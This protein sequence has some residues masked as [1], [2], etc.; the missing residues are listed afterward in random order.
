MHTTDT[1]SSSLGKT[2]QVY[3]F[4]YKHVRGAILLAAAI[5]TVPVHAN[6]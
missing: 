3:T 5:V 4:I 2:R 1:I 6:D